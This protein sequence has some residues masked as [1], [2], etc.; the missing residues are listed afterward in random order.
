MLGQAAGG[1]G[2]VTTGRDGPAERP[3]EERATPLP[4]EGPQ[5]Q[6]AAVTAP[7][8]KPFTISIFN[9][10]NAEKN[11][12]SRIDKIAK[13]HDV[14]IDGVKSTGFI[15]ETMPLQADLSGTVSGASS[16]V[17]SA[18]KALDLLDSEL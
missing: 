11:A 10:P 16:A 15:F 6:L 4:N 2:H 9:A 8:T 17:Q 18:L 7:V 13:V 14:K 3:A 12:Y 5:M 1:H